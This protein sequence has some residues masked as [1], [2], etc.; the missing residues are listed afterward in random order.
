MS[1]FIKQG[2]RQQKIKDKKEVKKRIK[3]IHSIMEE[4]DEVAQAI[5]LK[6]DEVI[7]EDNIVE[8]ASKYTDRP[9]EGYEKMILL[10]KLESIGKVKKENILKDETKTDI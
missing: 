4:L 2:L 5:I 6:D 1:N 7:T 3:A 9:I 10:S 8:I